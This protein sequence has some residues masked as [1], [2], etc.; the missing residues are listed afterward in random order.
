[1]ADAVNQTTLKRVL[2]PAGAAGLV[3]LL[4][5]VLVMQSSYAPKPG[6]AAGAAAPPGATGV[7]G[8]SDDS[9]PEGMA[10][11][12]PA[13]DAPE[14]KDL[15]DGIKTWDAKEGTGEACPA[16]ANVTIHYTGWTLAGSEFD[17]SVSTGKPANFPLTS[18]IQGWQRGIP[19]MKPGGVRRLYIPY[20]FAYGEAGSPPKI[21][22]R[23][24]LVFEV[25]LIAFKG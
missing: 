12:L 23:A 5:G 2:L 24:D 4:I 13:V 21:P 10:S 9:S 19:G 6:G 1:M 25:K 22:G 17:S 8:S 14:W 11:S 16:G 15:S 18:L 3:L 20:K 7:S